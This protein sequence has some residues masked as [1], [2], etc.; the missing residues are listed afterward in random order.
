VFVGGCTLEAAE[1]VCNADGDLPI[2]MLDGLAALVDKSL[3]KQEAG[4][5]G[6]PR[7]SM[8]ETIHE[9]VL[10]RLVESGE[11][12]LVRRRHALYFLATTIAG[13]EPTIVGNR[14]IT[15]QGLA[16]EL[17]NLRAAL[18]WALAQREAEIAQRLSAAVF[19]FAQDRTT[20][21]EVR[22]WLE[23]ALALSDADAASP[24]SREARASALGAAGQAAL[25]AGDYER[26]LACFSANLAVLQSLGDRPRIAL[27]QRMLGLVALLRGDLVE[28]QTWVA[29]SLA[30]CQETHEPEGIAWSLYDAGHLAFVRGDLTEAEGLLV[31]SLALLR[32][33]GRPDGVLRALSSMG[34]VARAQG[35]LARA[36]TCY[37]ESIAQAPI[38]RFISDTVFTLEGLAGLIGTLGHV[39]D[40]A[41]LFGAVAALRESSGPP[42]PPVARAA[43]ERD[44]GALRAQMG[45]AAFAAA[46]AAGQAMP[47]EQ[48]SDAALH[49]SLEEPRAQSETEAPS[50]APAAASAA[51]E[52]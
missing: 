6:E 35:Q 2:Q 41:Q 5:A 26:A 49:L 38:R 44:V 43:Y 32:A 27:A 12:A 4:V 14:V 28:A 7:F 42:L 33:Q 13:G 36:A 18:R 37:R 52:R 1:E 24:A 45:E 21:S 34:H 17:D 23:A 46:W 10:E 9:Y 15:R 19:A 3:L 47:L 20:L 30:L 25:D 22:A 39:A 51:P 48:A 11:E 40:A 50:K 8:L 16:A 31:E 29:Q